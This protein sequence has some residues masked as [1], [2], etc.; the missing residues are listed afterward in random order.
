VGLTPG[1]S[2]I[3]GFRTRYASEQGM[4]D[5]TSPVYEILQCL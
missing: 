1:S 4:E 3:I 2:A 5:G